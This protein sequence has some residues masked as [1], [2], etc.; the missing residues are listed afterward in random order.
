VFFAFKQIKKYQT[1][2]NEKNFL[3]V[4]NKMKIIY[5]INLV[6]FQNPDFCEFI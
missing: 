2:K 5:I 1:I 6:F 3:L 4:L